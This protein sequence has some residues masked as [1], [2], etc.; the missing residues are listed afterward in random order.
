VHVIPSKQALAL[1]ETSIGGKAFGL[2]RLGEVG[3]EVPPWFSV[4]VDAY[5]D[6][7]SAA[8]LD[9]P[10]SEGILA[11]SVPTGIANAIT[12]ALA[13]IGPGPFAV[14]SSM[15]GEDS[16][17]F[18]F[19]GQLDSFLFRSTPA[20]VVDAVKGCWA[21]AFSEHALTY[22]TRTGLAVADIR[23]A[24][25]VQR[26]IDSDVA[27]VLFTA[28]PVTG[29]RDHAL[30]TAAWGQGEGV[31][32][33]ECNTDEI[34]WQ[35]DGDEVSCTIADKD[36]KLVR[37]SDGA[38][39]DKI[40]V[41][42]ADRRRRCLSVA[43]AKRVCAEGVRVAREFDAPMDIEWTIADGTLYLL[44]ARPITSL[45]SPPNTDGPLIVW[46]NSNIQESYCGVTTPLTF[47]FASRAYE[48][49]YRQSAIALNVPV[50]LIDE[51]ATQL[52]NLLGLVRGRIYYN[53]NNWYLGLTLMPA[54]DRNKADME[55][56][57]GLQDPV[58]FV[59]DTKLSFFAKLARLPAMSRLAFR[60]LRMIKKLPKTVPAFL[61]NFETVY[62]SLD[63][64]TFAQASFSQLMAIVDR[65][66][67]EVLRRWQ[68][69]LINDMAVM[70]SNGALARLL[71]KTGLADHAALHN[72]LLAG[73]EG[74]ESTE[75]TKFL[76]RLAAQAR[77][78][79]ALAGVLKQGEPSQAFAAL[80]TGH[81]AFAA[82]LDEYI[83][84]YGDRTMGELKL[85]TISLR[86]DPGF[87]IEV[88]RNY[89][90]RPDLRADELA[91]REKKLRG[92]AE[93]KVAGA[94]GFF[95][96]RKFRKTVAANRRA[97][98]NRENMRLTRT[99]L[100]GLFRDLYRAVGQRLTEAGKLAEPRDVFYLTVGE[101]EEYHEGRAVTADFKGVVAARKA[102]F[103]EYEKTEL[104]HH[105]STRGPVYHGNT[106]RYDGVHEVDADAETL[107]GT[108]CY[109]GVVESP[110]RVIFSPKDELSVN[111]KILV[112]MRTD[113]GWAPLFPTTS[114]ILVERGSTLSHSAVVARELGIPAI[115]GIPGLTEILADGEQVRMDGATG[116]VTRLAVGGDDD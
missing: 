102:E 39:T 107:T 50:K 84:R 113:P 12:S 80:R 26:M 23:V 74:V 27:G 59:E 9:K 29:R 99:R 106:Y 116:K 109:P 47:S 54:F 62:R 63:R 110:V 100:F 16:S 40:D 111:G 52:R 46:D 7:V 71:E 88:L 96:R 15:V 78:D 45:P 11:A 79:S 22:Y 105:F 93:A 75:P 72:N 76:L 115:V 35:H 86:E 112:T 61:A 91:D 66:D 70:M 53:I 44:Q 57:M 60:L 20:E 42:E 5:S 4:P 56:M 24:V 34:V 37:S 65:L 87:V 90:D 73:E 95:A 32:S 13:T 19:A 94:L 30:L 28:N 6:F 17:E 64:S 48:T 67:K 98:K 8:G 82:Q 97:V 36:V 114:G 18:S 83:E 41:G 25:V 10:S 51:H 14:R 2:A 108:G 3:A 55:R 38:G 85:E 89:V 68:T 69:P 81:P 33:G 1:G 92:D 49:V 43:E 103:A 21:S 104:P 58:D 31:V 101:L 77:D